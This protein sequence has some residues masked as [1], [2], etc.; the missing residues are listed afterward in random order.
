LRIKIETFRQETLPRKAI[1]LLMITTFASKSEVRL[2]LGIKNMLA[3]F[4]LLSACANFGVKQNKYYGI[5]QNEVTIDDL[6]VES[7]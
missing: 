4:V 6:F 3:Y 5:I 1:H 7:D 2:R